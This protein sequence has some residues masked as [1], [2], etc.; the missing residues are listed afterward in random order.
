MERRACQWGPCDGLGDIHGLSSGWGFGRLY[1]LLPQIRGTRLAHF[2]PRSRSPS[3]RP[4]SASQ[5]ASKSSSSTRNSNSGPIAHRSENT[6]GTGRSHI[7]RHNSS[8][9]GAA[10]RNVFA[11]LIDL[12]SRGKVETDGPPVL[13]KLMPLARGMGTIDTFLKIP[14]D[15]TERVAI[16]T[17]PGVAQQE[18]LT[19][20]Q[21]VVGS[22]LPPEPIKSTP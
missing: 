1:G 8:L 17:S 20:N 14:L 11:H 22:I 21:L 18:Q 6:Q 9:L 15:V 19:V 12:C 4:Q 13:K 16:S 7:Y 2:L 5:L 10:A 3:S